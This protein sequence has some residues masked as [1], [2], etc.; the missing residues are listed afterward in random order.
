MPGHHAAIAAAG[1]PP[2]AAGHLECPAGEPVLRVDRP[3]PGDADDPVK[4]AVSY[5]DPAH[6]SY[7]AKLRR[8]PS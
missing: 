8:G 7:R 5:F 3:Q 4:L 6:Y 2:F 1:T